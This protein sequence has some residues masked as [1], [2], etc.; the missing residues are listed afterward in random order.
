M[1]SICEA[2]IDGI[3]SLMRIVQ[4]MTDYSAMPQLICTPLAS[5]SNAALVLTMLAIFVPAAYMMSTSLVRQESTRAGDAQS[6]RA[7]FD[8]GAESI[9]LLVAKVGV[10]P[11]SYLLTPADSY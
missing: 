1:L 7:A 6:I 8:F 11:T 3:C 9:K 2:Y 4:P 10:P 5:V